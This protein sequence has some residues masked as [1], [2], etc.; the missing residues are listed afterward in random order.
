M[1]DIIKKLRKELHAYPEVSGQEK[2]TAKRVEAFIRKHNDT[3]IIKN[4]G[5]TG[6]AAIYDFGEGSTV[7]IRCELDA[8]P[9]PRIK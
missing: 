5:N 3:K 8:L 2:E 1:I 6:V 7:M 9:I 4:L